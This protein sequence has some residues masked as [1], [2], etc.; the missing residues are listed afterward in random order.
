MT[1][2]NRNRFWFI[3]FLLLCFQLCR[4]QAPSGDVSFS[5]GG[6]TAPVFD[7]N[8]SL[9]LEQEII[10]AGD[11]TTPLSFG[12]NVVHDARGRL[13]GTGITFVNVG[14]DGVFANYVIRGTASGGGTRAN[15][16]SITVK[17]TGED[18][19]AGVLT[20]FT[21]T[22]HYNLVG[23]PGSQTL[24]GTARGTAS[25][26]NLSSAGIKSDVTV[27][28]QASMDGSWTAN[29]KILALQRLAGTGS[30]VLSSG[31]SLPTTLLGTYSSRSAVANIR[32]TGI[33]EARGTSVQLNFISSEEGTEIQLVRGKNLRQT[34]R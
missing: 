2:C 10:G 15:R 27:Q 16:F 31:R 17:L 8:G 7:L 12:V 11:Q 34:V 33:N 19:V 18:F 22:V 21:I 4:A 28:L 9:S 24:T 5:F 30:I 26:N 6:D 20:R 14:N 3:A 13:S 1:I 23:D 25:F 32:M 29:M